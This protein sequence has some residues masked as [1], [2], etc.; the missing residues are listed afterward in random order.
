MYSLSLLALSPLVRPSQMY[1]KGSDGEPAGSIL[2][3]ADH[4]FDKAVSSP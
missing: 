1:Q 2:R 4:T 3:S